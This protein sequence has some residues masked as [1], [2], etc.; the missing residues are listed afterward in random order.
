VLNLY[1]VSAFRCC[2]ALALLCL[3]GGLRAGAQ[4]LF[5][6]RGN[7]G[8][9]AEYTPGG[10]FVQQFVGAVMNDPHGMKFGPNGDLYVADYLNGAIK[11]FNGVTG[12]A[13]PSGTVTGLASLPADVAFNATGD[14]FVSAYSAGSVDRVSLSSHT[15]VQTYSGISGA[16]GMIVLPNGHVL[17]CSYLANEVIDL[18]PVTG[19]TSVFG[20]NVAGP[21]ALTMGPDGRIYVVSN[22]GNR[23]DVIAATGGVASVFATGVSSPGF[24]VFDNGNLYVTGGPGFEEFNGT[25]GALINSFGTVDNNTFGIAVR[26]TEAPTETPEPGSLALI[27]AL[28]LAGVNTLLRYTRKQYR[29]G[30]VASAGTAARGVQEMLRLKTD[31]SN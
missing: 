31:R 16:Y 26:N 8:D 10:T 28:T 20:T 24:D 9:I 21:V 6:A 19:L 22:S 3:L 4:D 12:A 29:A 15:V 7:F 18:D 11:E 14:M 17:V 23:V 30:L 2:T 13:V 25:T 1:R 5:V 27:A